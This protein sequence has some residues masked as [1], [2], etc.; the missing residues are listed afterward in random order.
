MQLPEVWIDHD[1]A[2]CFAAWGHHDKPTMMAAAKAHVLASL[3][4]G[5]HFPPGGQCCPRAYRRDEV[6]V[7]CGKVE[8]PDVEACYQAA[9]AFWWP[10]KS[11]SE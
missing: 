9:M 8:H 6:H 2:E 4:S 7:Y 3:G 10:K 11:S 5:R 1:Y